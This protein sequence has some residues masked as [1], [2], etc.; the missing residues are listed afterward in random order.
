MNKDRRKELDA[1]REKLVI[2]QNQWGAMQTTL[3]DVRDELTGVKEAEQ[4]SFDALPESVQNGER[5]EKMSTAI[6]EMENAIDAVNELA[7][8]EP[9]F[10]TWLGNIDTAKE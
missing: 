4:E 3:E 5:G 9:D 7:E 10:D 1:I 6:S 8:N 2:A